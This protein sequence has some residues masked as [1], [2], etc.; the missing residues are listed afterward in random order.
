[1]W[2]LAFNVTWL[3][4]QCICA[5]YVIICMLDLVEHET[6]AGIGWARLSPLSLAL[7]V[8]L[9]SNR[10]KRS[11]PMVTGNIWLLLLRASYNWFARDNRIDR[12]RC[13]ALFNGKITF[14]SMSLNQMNTLNYQS[15]AYNIATI[16]N[17]TA[18][19]FDLTFQKPSATKLYWH[20]I[21]QQQKLKRMR[22]NELLIVPIF[23]HQH[24]PRQIIS[25]IE[26][27]S[28]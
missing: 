16:D 4:C 21:N 2:L 24:A 11:D 20:T 22:S 19:K 25:E 7:H 5:F 23:C 28:S 17:L 12:W 9:F 13:M 10:K 6:L 8:F 14:P 26:Q 1:M 3:C 18:N 27:D 15:D